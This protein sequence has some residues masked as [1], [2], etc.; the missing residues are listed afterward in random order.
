MFYLSIP[1]WFVGPIASVVLVWFSLF[2]IRKSHRQKLKSSWIKT[3]LSWM[4]LWR[5]KSLTIELDELFR[6]MY[7]YLL[8]WRVNQQEKDI[9]LSYIWFILTLFLIKETKKK[10]F[11]NICIRK[12]CMCERMKKKMTWCIYV[13]HQIGFWK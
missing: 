1:C 5:I 12:S 6:N 11:Y 7:T 13:F 3:W 8:C 4:K 10:F 2:R 9:V